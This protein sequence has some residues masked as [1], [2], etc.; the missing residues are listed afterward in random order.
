M[1]TALRISGFAIV[2]R[3][4][5]EFGPG[6]NVV[7]GETGA[8]KSILMD[9]LHL[10]LG[11][12]M[13]SDVLRDGAD[14][15]VVEALF[16]LPPGHA[17]LERVAASGLPA[18]A[19]SGELLVRRTSSRSGRGRAFINGALCTVG[20][21]ET[22]LRGLLDVTAQ[23][24]H[25]SLLDESTHLPLLDAFA[26]AAGDGG[27]GAPYR[28]AWA[29]LEQ[30]RR[31]KE[32]LVA[33]CEGRARRA[34]ELRFAV[35]EIE[36][37]RP[38]R[39][40]LE[41]LERERRV[42]AGAEKL[43][44]AARTCEALVYGED[45]SAAERIGR[46]L[47]AMADA[48]AVDPRLEPV[49]G[50]LR[51]ASAEVDDAGRA[52][53]RY[54]EA[55][56]S[57]PERLAQVEERLGLLRA[58]ARR[59]GGTLDAVLERLAAMRQELATVEGAGERLD[60]L[61][62][63]AR[64]AAAAAIARAAELTEARRKAATAIGREVRRE[65]DALAM[66]RCTLEV[67]F[68]APDHGVVHGGVTLGPSGAESA[69]LLLSVNPGEPPRPLARIASGGELSRIVLALK[70]ALARIDPVE[71]YVLDEVDAG[72]GGGV[73]E[74]VGRLLA[75]VARERQ[76]ICVT[77]LPQVAAFAE[78]HLRV[79]K[80]VRGGRTSASVSTL[81]SPDER[82]VEVA[83]M[84]AGMTVTDSALQHA[85]ALID[86]A[87]SRA[88]APGPG[89]EQGCRIGRRTRVAESRGPQAAVR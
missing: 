23:H 53:V 38:A 62:A 42:L 4:E 81:A 55:I 73:A 74:A 66:G 9:A 29:R 51:A 40:E 41:Q 58:L 5:V 68:A 43:R 1:L 75:R 18:P 10:V 15:V 77:H 24:E 30:V 13:G 2:D 64:E 44:G 27:P 65:L 19:G 21:L 11:G 84:L 3:V 76:V 16:E 83:R 49:V 85:R 79:E 52:L 71:T 88:A 61:E 82:R 35:Q 72:I 69:R 28:E 89:R 20:M 60:Q 8:G 70:R 37:V 78:H 86:G 87:R 57:D 47:R 59:H 50:S 7:T 14:E 63:A 6:L 33:A 48:A 39:G 45:G 31:E 36:A 32:A 12:R 80:R 56:D 22:C 54:A 34:E 26:G 17:V 46:A 67:A 25:V